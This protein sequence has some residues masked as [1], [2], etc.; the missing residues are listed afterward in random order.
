M[1]RAEDIFIGNTYSKIIQDLQTYDKKISFD[2]GKLPS[3]Y[4]ENGEPKAQPGK[5]SGLTVVLDAHSDLISVGSV[6]IDTYGFFG[7]LQPSGSFPTKIFGLFDIKP[8]HKNNIAISATVVNSDPELYNLAQ[9]DRNCL[10]NNEN[11]MLKL[12]KNYTQSNCFFECFLHFAQSVIKQKYN[13]LQHCIPWYLPT[14]EEHPKICNPWEAVEFVKIMSNVPQNKCQHC[15]PDCTLTIY[16]TLVT[17]VPL[18]TCSLPCLKTTPFCNISTST[19]STTTMIGNLVSSN[20]QMRFGKTPENT[21]KTIKTSNRNLGSSIVNGHYFGPGD[22][23]YD[24]FSRDIAE[25][26]I[27]F[28]TAT[29]VEIERQP[30]MTWIDFFSNIGGLLGLVLGIGIVTLMELIWLSY[31]FGNQIL[32]VQRH[33]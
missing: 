28:K 9:T 30:V 2:G 11:E 12:Y 29:A 31:Q 33:L 7:L 27:F 23:G 8:G 10:F 26:K 21:K 13:M 14:S 1:Q 17:A 3:H 22:S 18:R 5:T 16:K 32:P 24:A 6:E 19:E 20:F 15:L 4:I 25:V